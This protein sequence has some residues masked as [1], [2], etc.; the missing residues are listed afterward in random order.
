[1]QRHTLSIYTCTCILYSNT[2]SSTV[3]HL[4]FIYIQMFTRDGDGFD[5]DDGA[6]VLNVMVCTAFN[7]KRLV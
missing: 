4:Q 2:I 3:I 7:M 6:V 1:M 5:D